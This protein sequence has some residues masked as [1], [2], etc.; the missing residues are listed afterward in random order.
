ML[1]YIETKGPNWLSLLHLPFPH[2]LLFAFIYSPLTRSHRLVYIVFIAWHHHNPEPDSSF[3]SQF[4]T[5]NQSSFVSISAYSE[6]GLR[7]FPLSKQITMLNPFAAVM[8]HQAQSYPTYSVITQDKNPHNRNT[9]GSSVESLASLC[10][11]STASTTERAPLSA[12]TTPSK[13]PVGHH[14]PFL[15]PKIR[16]Q[17]S[18]YDATIHQERHF[19]SPLSAT[20]LS[21]G[22]NGYLTLS[23]DV[24]NDYIHSAS[25]NYYPMTTPLDPSPIDTI[26]SPIYSLGVPNLAARH[27]LPVPSSFAPQPTIPSTLSPQWY[28]SH[29]HT[30]SHSSIQPFPTHPH[31]A[32]S[33]RSSS[34]ETIRVKST[35]L[36]SHSLPNT[37]LQ[38]PPQQLHPSCAGGD[39]P[40]T[41]LNAYMTSPN[42]TPALVQRLK[43]SGPRIRAPNEADYWWDI[44]SLSRWETFAPST[45]DSIVGLPQLLRTEM[46]AADLPEPPT[47]TSA[48]FRHL[49]RPERESDLAELVD[50]FFGAKLNAAL[51]ATQGSESHM[52]MTS[53]SIRPLPLPNT[54]PGT[55]AAAAV[56]PARRS[57][58]PDFTSAYP[59]DTAQTPT[60][61]PR[62]R[63][64]GI[65]RSFNRWNSGM[66]HESPTRQVEYLAGLAALHRH[67]RTHGC[68]YGF[69]ISE[70]ELVCVRAV[71]EEEEEEGAEGEGTAGASRKAVFG[72]LALAPAVK[73]SEHDER[74]PAPGVS[75]T[76]TSTSTSTPTPS[77]KQRQPLTAVQALW[78]LHMLA[79]RSP[80]PG[81]A[82]WRLD[83]GPAADC[84]RKNCRARDAWMPLIGMPEKREARRVRG[85]VMP[86]DG[87]SRKE[88]PR[89]QRRA[90]AVR[91]G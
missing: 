41:T 6:A 10:S 63:V 12:I 28:Q 61:E 47:S 69:I 22:S 3:C 27:L 37:T 87:L 38:I 20:A 1:R 73:L 56:A 79:K 15:L 7:L 57:A 59:S 85:W 16:T 86:E 44:R 74:V 36:R 32:P 77:P 50:K 30:R 9:S 60:G 29:A 70:I 65:V 33:L 14:G 23:Y 90:R 26:L 42:P 84:T 31:S 8:S 2:P 64:V 82:D 72:A 71:T 45:I 91:R 83:V 39:S 48:R 19:R 52:V 21:A 18:D 49:L 80:L 67:M 62:G 66:R 55:E 13:S 51:V 40:V 88:I 24:N 4:Y 11:Q 81:Q 46:S 75:P 58:A 17:D 5:S 35:H 25:T 89:G 76:S 34:P 68:R 78:F 54:A 53:T 43:S